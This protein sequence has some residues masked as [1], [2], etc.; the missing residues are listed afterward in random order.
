MKKTENKL[1]DALR[2]LRS[3]FGTLDQMGEVLGVDRVTVHR[4][5]AGKSTPKA[6]ML[7]K[8]AKRALESRESERL[9]IAFIEPIA[10]ES[11]ATKAALLIALLVDAAYP[12]H[13]PS[14]AEMKPILARAKALLEE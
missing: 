12:S 9:A 13:L 1:G 7:V 5:E 14:I 8:M 11:G 2:E 10:E 4:C 3:R 6:P